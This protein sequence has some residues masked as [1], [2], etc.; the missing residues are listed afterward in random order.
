[1]NMS[2]PPDASI[3][4]ASTDEAAKEKTTV[5]PLFAS[6]AWPASLNASVSE[7]AAK[8][9]RSAA[10]PA[11]PAATHS[12]VATASRAFRNQAMPSPTFQSVILQQI[13]RPRGGEQGMDAGGGSGAIS[14]TWRG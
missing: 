10:R 9:V 14:Q 2:A 6:Q 13:S 8:T 1:M 11:D 4:R 12:I 5:W 7:A 3:W